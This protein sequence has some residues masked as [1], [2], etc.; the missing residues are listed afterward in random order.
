M[1]YR[2]LGQ[3]LK[4]SAVGLGC[5]PMKAGVA[6]YGPADDD[7]STATI[8]AALDLGVTFFDTAEAYGPHLNEELLGRA[9]R[10]R[11]D[12]LVIATK[13]GFRYVDNMA[14]L[15]VDGSP[16]NA[17]RSCEGSLRRLGTDRIDL[18]YQHR[19]DPSV[20]IEETMGALAELVREGKILHIGLSEAGAE[21]IRRAHA[22]HPV[23]AVQTEYSLW[24]R[25]VEE[26][27]LPVTAELGIGFVPYSPL[28]RGFLA[29]NAIP[30]SRM[31]EGDWRLVDPRYAPGNYEANMAIVDAIR[32]VAAAKDVSLARIAIAWL[33][34]K[35]ADIV[36][37]PGAKRRVT[38][39][40]SM[41][42]AEVS[43]S[44]EDMARL[45]AIGSPAGLRYPEQMLAGLNI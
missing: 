42:A 7:E 14:V 37:I 4:V 40:D 44:A 16:E 11:R 1:Q 13:W 9:I 20:P 23:T 32:S 12:G 17:R 41:A 24:E 26:D 25:G 10:G 8:Q 6:P 33:L 3:G 29:G 15:G 36:P 30:R 18:Y 35:R 2:V 5:M 45:D 38:M 43:L 39:A 22:V 34:A 21:T 27:V 31:S 19:M 28:G